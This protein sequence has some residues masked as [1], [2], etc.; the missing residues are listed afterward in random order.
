MIRTSSVLFW[1]GLVII[2]SLALYRT[3][4]RVHE[5]NARLREVNTAIENEQ[6]S[7][8]VLKAE[9]VY[10]ANPARV[11]AAA[12]KHLALRPTSPQQVTELSSLSEVLPTRSEAMASVAISGTPIA[13]IK[14]SLEPMPTRVATIAVGAKHAKAPITVASADTGHINDHMIMQRTASAAP[15]PDSIGNLITELGEH[16]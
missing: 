5:L 12:H 13:N 4:D 3:S 14:S 7:I 6:Q 10:L 8:H 2:A 9:W 1:F 11:E 16:Q 15:S